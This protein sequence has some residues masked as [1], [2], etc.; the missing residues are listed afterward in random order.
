MVIGARQANVDQTLHEYQVEA[1][2]G[3]VVIVDNSLKINKLLPQ[4]DARYKFSEDDQLRFGFSQTYVYPDFREFSSSGYFHP[5]EAATVIGNPDLVSTD[6]TNVDARF[7]HYYSPTESWSAA[8]FYKDLENP[9]EDVSVPSTS[10]PIYSYVNTD[11]AILMGLELDIYKNFDFI[12]SA[13]KFYYVSSNFTYTNSDVSLSAQ[14][15][16]QYTSNHR[17]LQGLS[18]MVFNATAGYDNNDGRSI[19]FSY[20]KMSKRIRKVGL[21]NGIQEYPDQYEIPPHIL[22][23][24]YQERLME[25]L[26]MR[27]KARNLINGDIIWEEGKNVTKRYKAGRSYEISLSYKY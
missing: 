17:A 9:I 3:N 25:G 10:L 12:N 24:T 20:N 15:Q 16:S 27:F 7:E 19:N 1:S 26:D 2:S 6:I 22:D 14:Q 5:D 11:Q 8:L 13:M 4:L 23:F 18:P 21:K